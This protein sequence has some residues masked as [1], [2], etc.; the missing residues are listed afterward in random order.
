MS[1]ALKWQSSRGQESFKSAT[2]LA[3][4]EIRVFLTC[5]CHKIYRVEAVGTKKYAND[6]LENMLWSFCENVTTTFDIKLAWKI[7]I[8]VSHMNISHLNLSARM[9]KILLHMCGIHVTC[10]CT[11]SECHS[12]IFVSC[13]NAILSYQYKF[14][15]P[16][17][18]FFTV[19]SPGV[20]SKIRFLI[21]N[22]LSQSS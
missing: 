11:L 12:M 15:F 17:F 20:I 21:E 8:Y 2:Q 1:F 19:R 16:D 3:I 14:P 4:N 7:L 5:P 18:A 13:I 22:C 10:K 9:K 6:K